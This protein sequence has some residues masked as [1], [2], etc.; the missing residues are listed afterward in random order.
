MYFVWYYPFFLT[1]PDSSFSTVC[2]VFSKYV[3]VCEAVDA[4]ITLSIFDLFF[5]PLRTGVLFLPEKL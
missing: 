2:K 5:S 1:F 4:A 3:C